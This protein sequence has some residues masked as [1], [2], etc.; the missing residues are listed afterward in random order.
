MGDYEE[1]LAIW[2]RYRDKEITYQEFE[3]QMNRLL[4]KEQE[5]PD[6]AAQKAQE[7]FEGEWLDDKR[8]GE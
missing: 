6:Q 7:L 5:Y 4:H 2:R 8:Y 3:E 1:S